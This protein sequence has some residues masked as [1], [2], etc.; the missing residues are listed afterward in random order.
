MALLIGFVVLAG[1]RLLV[2]LDNARDVDQVRP[3]L[4]GARGCVVVVTSRNQLTGL[5][6]VEGAHP[7]TLEQLNPADARRLLATRL[8]SGRVTDAP[9]A[10]D[11]IVAACAGLPLALAIVAAR[12]A[13]YPGFL[14]HAFAEELSRSRGPARRVRHRRPAA[15]VRTV[16]S[17]SYDAL[18]PA[19]ARLFR[20]L[21][22]HPGPDFTAAAAASLAG[23]PVPKTA[24]LLADHTRV[25]L[26][27]EHMP[28]RYTFHDLLRA[29]AAEVCHLEEPP[30]EQRAAIHRMLDHYLHTT[31]AAAML[32]QPLRDP[33]NLACPQPG[34]TPEPVAD[35]GQANAYSPNTRYCSRWSHSPHRTGHSRS[36]TPSPGHPLSGIRWFG[37]RGRV[38]GEFAPA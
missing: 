21:G 19:A 18:S 7:V 36:R 23:I 12:A 1:R 29:Y 6:A 28:G 31:H 9:E 11:D 2:V 3:L 26:I 32:L 22:L 33:I 30:A 8:G 15:D 13:S 14:L 17:W 38:A 4:P 24:R 35:V 16:F 27:A 34:V 5:V 37:A 20:L 25:H 10:V